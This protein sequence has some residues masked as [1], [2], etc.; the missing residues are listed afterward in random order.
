MST[1]SKIKICFCAF[2]IILSN[3]LNAASIFHAV[4]SGD[5]EYVYEFLYCSPVNTI[6]DKKW[7]TD[8]TPL[9]QAVKLGHEEIVVLLI[10]WN[11]DVNVGNILGRTPLHIA[12]SGIERK[13]F[14]ILSCIQKRINKTICNALLEAGADPQKADF[15]GLIPLDF[16]FKLEKAYPELEEKLRSKEELFV[17]IKRP[18]KDEDLKAKDSRLFDA[19]ESRDLTFL[20]QFLN[21]PYSDLHLKNSDGDTWEWRIIKSYAPLSEIRND[22]DS[23]D[24]VDEY[25]F[26]MFMAKN[27]DPHVLD[28]DGNSLL[29]YALDKAGDT[30][31]P[32]PSQQAVFTDIALVL[33]ERGAS[34]DYICNERSPLERALEF[35]LRPVVRALLECGCRASKDDLMS[36]ERRYSRDS[37]EYK[38]LLPAFM[39][40]M[41]SARK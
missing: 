19:L 22:D 5:V 27:G 23:E 31:F 39:K 35:N 38:I 14:G 29:N 18:K 10:G 11:A 6:H 7:P 37:E 9:H 33:I 15:D 20:K 1:I 2:V 32:H 34:V 40:G 25:Q 30:F 17:R 28:N 8:N 21:D 3:V 13:R 26:L 41:K 12:C 36:I 4:E 16:L 24:I